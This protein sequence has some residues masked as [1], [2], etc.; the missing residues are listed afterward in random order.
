MSKLDDI[1]IFSK[2]DAETVYQLNRKLL[3][4]VI[5]REGYCEV[6]YFVLK[7]RLSMPTSENYEFIAKTVSDNLADIF[8]EIDKLN[9][10]SLQDFSINHQ[11]IG[12]T[13]ARMSLG[14]MI[15][16][17]DKIKIQCSLLKMFDKQ[18]DVEGCIFSGNPY[19]HV[20]LGDKNDV[21]VRMSIYKPLSLHALVEQLT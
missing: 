17:D 8:D 9:I 21:S 11:G 2:K 12:S 14:D 16:G 3:L 10:A 5:Q 20:D 13:R 1:K 15:L 18:T 7:K 4:K 19:V 6:Y